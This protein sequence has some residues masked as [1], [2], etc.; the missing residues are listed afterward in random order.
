MKS[1]KGSQPSA[2][3]DREGHWDFDRGDGGARQR[4]LP[5]GTEVDHDNNPVNPF[6][7]LLPNYPHANLPRPELP[8][9]LRPD[10]P[11]LRGPGFYNPCAGG[12]CDP[13]PSSPGTAPYFIP[14]GTPGFSPSPGTNPVI[15][16]N[17]VFVG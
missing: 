10:P 17:P 14:R 8:E 11:P 7:D 3:W 12:P 4:F 6:K 13:I 9:K 15:F 1:P 5:D 16:D 2:S